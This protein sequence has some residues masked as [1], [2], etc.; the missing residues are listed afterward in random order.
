MVD[1]VGSLIGLDLLGIQA[2]HVSPVNLGSGM[3]ETA[4][5]RLPVPAPATAEILKGLPLYSSAI[6]FEL[7]TPTGAAILKG[8]AQPSAMPEMTV[9][10]IGC[11]AGG[12]EIPSSPNIL[13]LF[14]GEGA[15]G[16]QEDRVMVI[17][18]NIDDMNPQIYEDVMEKLF[19]AGAMDVWLENI[20]MKKGRPAVKLTVLC[21]E[22]KA[23]LIGDTIFRET[24]SIG[25]RYGTTRRRTL[26]RKMIT[27]ETGYGAVRVKVS[28]LRGDIV[29]AMTEYEDLKEISGRTGIPI[30]TLVAE[31]QR[32]AGG[33]GDISR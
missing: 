8:L 25:L 15:E 4:H 24:T 12:R 27:V 19:S 13:R 11:G 14:I 5:G 16:I 17:E 10:K 28:R 23:Q 30:K 2:V 29:N 21:P 18:T 33:S 26:E 31:I 1:I 7:T 9:E 20:I 32:E 22:E 3:V 6:P